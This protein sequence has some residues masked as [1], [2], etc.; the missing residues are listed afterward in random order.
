MLVLVR[1]RSGDGS[2]SSFFVRGA[3]N[4]SGWF[5]ASGSAANAT[6]GIRVDG[7]RGW[8]RCSD[9][10]SGSYKTNADL[11][12]MDARLPGSQASRRTDH[13]CERSVLNHADR[14]RASGHSCTRRPVR[15]LAQAARPRPS[16]SR[17]SQKRR[18]QRASS[19]AS[20]PMVPPPNTGTQRTPQRVRS[21]RLRVQGRRGR[22][23]ISSVDS[24]WLPTCDHTLG[25]LASEIRH[26]A[27]NAPADGQIHA[28]TS[29]YC[30]VI[31]D[32]LRRAQADL[33]PIESAKRTDRADAT[34]R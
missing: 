17:C 3:H 20:T 32:R 24:A 13:S 18:P 31:G 7:N 29:V 26:C 30:S 4:Q 9:P 34:P 5:I 22:C 15:W 23:S 33:T 10:G 16:L 21:V 11:R 28:E 19:A 2:A 12:A 6:S 1:G 8:G 14:T 25:A 27:R